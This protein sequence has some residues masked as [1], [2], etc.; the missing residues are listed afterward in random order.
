MRVRPFRPDDA[1]FL[2]RIFHSAVH[3]IG[4]HHY[5][6]EQIAAWAPA[7]P[8]QETFLRRGRDGRLLLVAV[9][10]L[11]RPLAY[12]DLEA[13]G[14][15]DHL[16]CRP[17]MAGTGVASFLYDRIEAA[18]AERGLG[19]LFV[20]AS[21]PARRFFLKKGFVLLRRR[22]FELGNVP[23]HNFEMEKQLTKTACTSPAATG[24][25][26]PSRRYDTPG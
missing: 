24:V 26:A 12:G 13:D 18:A 8:P 21:E 16:Y 9:D 15:I 7:L 19:R 2:A 4:R 14:H 5:S 23:I 3:R 10:D 1:P 22:D 25:T 6:A 11:D 20:E 17:D